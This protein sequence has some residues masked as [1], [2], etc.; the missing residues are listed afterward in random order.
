MRRKDKTMTK[1]KNWNIMKETQTQEERK[2]E[3]II[4]RT[5]AK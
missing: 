2:E 4:A 5:I 1:T 3:K